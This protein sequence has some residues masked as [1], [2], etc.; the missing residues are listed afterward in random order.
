MDVDCYLRR[1]GVDRPAKPDADALARLHEAHLLAVP[2]ENLSI[3]WGE[4][5][6][7]DEVR[8]YRKI[9]DG[10][11]GG[12]CYELNTLF[13]WGLRALGY[14]VDVLSARVWR[15]A[16]R[17]G[18]E[19]DHMCLRVRASGQDWLADVGFGD[20]FRRPM[21]VEAGWGHADG[22]ASYTL[23]R[24]GAGF[25]LARREGGASWIPLYRFDVVPRRIDEFASMLSYH[26]TS[27]EAPFTR[28]RVCSVATAWGRVT[29][30]DRALVRTTLDGGRTEE[31]LPDE[32][33]WAAALRAHFGI[34]CTG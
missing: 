2:F 10:R 5:I 26:Q 11:R 29:L 6:V 18:P 32:S 31:S 23:R 9:V 8:L 30:T 27:P 4:P 19:F 3:T 16:D 20:S 28:R 17:F 14:H 12:G 21:V 7:L 34:E 15:D 13:A 33:G 1:M 25:E 22:H 24:A